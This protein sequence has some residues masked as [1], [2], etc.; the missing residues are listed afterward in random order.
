MCNNNLRL[1][2]P[3][4]R[5]QHRNF[6]FAHFLRGGGVTVILN[7]KFKFCC[8]NQGGV[9]GRVALA[10]SSDP[11]TPPQNLERALCLC[12]PTDFRAGTRCCN[13]LG[14]DCDGQCRPNTTG[15][16]RLGERPFSLVKGY[17]IIFAKDNPP[18]D[19]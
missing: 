17:T 2:S 14:L 1:K 10:K 13:N 8:K 9:V 7:L 18:K 19:T 15:A 12:D 6:D 11:A 16:S 3:L 4:T 5:S